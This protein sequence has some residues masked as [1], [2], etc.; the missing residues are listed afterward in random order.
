MSD[1]GTRTDFV[2]FYFS[3]FSLS[4]AAT[5]YTGRFFDVVCFLCSEPVVAFVA[6]YSS[7]SLSRSKSK[8]LLVNSLIDSCIIYNLFADAD[9]LQFRSW[10]A[11]VGWIGSADQMYQNKISVKYHDSSSCSTTRRTAWRTSTRDCRYSLRTRGRLTNT[12][13]GTI[14]SPV[15]TSLEHAFIKSLM[16]NKSMTVRL[17]PCCS[18]AEP[19]FR[20]DFCWVQKA[21][22]LGWTAGNVCCTEH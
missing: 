3:I 1:H 7:L 12:M 13:R 6:L 10:M 20:H 14:L 5:R 15:R 8:Y 17:M 18:E 9:E 11:L 21:V 4:P 2:G 22:P 19:V 16:E